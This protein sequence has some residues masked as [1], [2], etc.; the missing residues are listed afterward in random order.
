MGRKFNLKTD[1]DDEYINEVVDYVNNKINNLKSNTQA[2][3]ALDLALLSAISIADSYFELKEKGLKKLNDLSSKTNK[4]ISFI[5]N[6][7]N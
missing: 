5:D 4:I 3:S 1:R 6:K 2:T 7:I